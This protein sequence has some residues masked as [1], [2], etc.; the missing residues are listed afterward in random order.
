MIL[1]FSVNRVVVTLS[2]GVDPMILAGFAGSDKKYGVAMTAH[3]VLTEAGLRSSFID[4]DKSKE[5]ADAKI[6][7][8]Y[9]SELEK[10]GV[11][12]VVFFIEYDDILHAGYSDLNF[13]IMVSLIDF[14]TDNS[15]WTEKTQHCV[16]KIYEKVKEKGTVIVNIDDENSLMTIKGIKAYIITFGFNLKASLTASS[17]GDSLNESNHIFCLQRAIRNIRNKRIEPQE[18]S[19]KLLK[20][21]R[22]NIYDALA[23]TAFALVCGID[24][25]QIMDFLSIGG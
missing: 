7:R 25:C 11:D 5:L 12:V 2:N 9:L 10:N 8:H 3:G 17:V 6:L 24:A 4:S 23:I 21:E 1:D 18:F 20:H 16:R 15:V 19:V 22:R 14:D 13:D